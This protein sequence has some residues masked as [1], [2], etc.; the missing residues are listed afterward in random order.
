MV[1]LDQN[2]DDERRLSEKAEVAKL[3]YP[4][5]SLDQESLD[6]LGLEKLPSVGTEIPMRAIVKVSEV[7]ESSEGESRLVLHIQH[8]EFAPVEEEKIF[9]KG[10]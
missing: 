10:K 5:L 4:E 2:M 6:R 9:Y 3:K 7:K 1:P 8:M